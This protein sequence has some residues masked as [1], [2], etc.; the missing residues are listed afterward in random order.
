MSR[1][2]IVIT[3][4]LLV[5]ATLIGSYAHA[6]S[7]SPGGVGATNF[8]GAVTGVKKLVSV[9]HHDISESYRLGRLVFDDQFAYLSTPDGLFRTAPTIGPDSQ[10]K[11]L[12]FANQR[13]WNLYVEHN[14]LY[15]L[16]EGG[17][18]RTGSLDA[19]SFLKSVDHGATFTPLDE[20][21]QYCYRDYC[22]YL[23]ATHAF[24]KNN[25]I[26]LAAG[27]GNNFFVSSDEG[28][29]WTVLYGSLERAACSDAAVEMIEKKVLFGGEC[30]LDAG[31]LLVGTLR[32]DMLGWAEGGSPRRVMGLAELENRNV[33]FIR[34][35][36][37]TSFAL[38]GVEGGLL[39]TN[40]L[41]ETYQFKIR[42]PLTGGTKYPYIHKVLIP[43]SYRDLI[44]AGGFNKKAQNGY[45]VYSIDHGETWTDISDFI[46]APEFTAADVAF[47][48]QDPSGRVLIG[49]HGSDSK[50]LTITEAVIAAPPT[51]LTD[52]DQ[53]RALA[54]DSVTLQKEPFSLFT[55]HNF[56]AD[57]RTRISLF[58]TNIN[59]DTASEI[60]VR[61][62]DGQHRTYSLP[63][64]H[65]GTI[66]RFP[67][68][69][70]IVVLLPDASS[71][72][73]Q[74][75]VSVTFK[76]VESN[77]AFLRIQ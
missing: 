47:I 68:I 26:F 4:T 7:Q 48:T 23:Y 71:N 38:A 41:G 45:L 3:R 61:A 39:K 16:K 34:F 15:V 54:L 37:N 12:G 67:W 29:H 74:V 49:I 64:E 73:G 75:Q 77:R 65:L 46:L 21:L 57:G 58:A 63:I 30:P 69:T 19:H 70:Q 44:L 5:L 22:E 59:S 6:F 17:D 35:S 28:K 56:S 9:A 13:I 76:G 36:P 14:T 72:A 51:L 27:G 55:D 2:S 60:S 20:G 1:K 25:L 11:F 24:F 42:Y 8:T 53:D 66:S 31:Y 62:E 43:V 50:T 33:Q 18:P 32:D 10:F 52:S 40:D